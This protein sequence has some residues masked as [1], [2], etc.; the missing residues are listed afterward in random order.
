LSLLRFHIDPLL[1][2]IETHRSVIDAA[3]SRPARW[4]G[5][6]RSPVDGKEGSMRRRRVAKAFNR[7][8]RT[9]ARSELG[10]ITIDDLLRLNS[11]VGG[12]GTLRTTG[13]RIGE[14]AIHHRRDALPGLAEQALN[15]ANDG[16]EPP[17]LAAARLHMELLLIHGFRDCNGRTIRLASAWI[18]L[19]AGY[20]STLL[21]AVEQHAALVPGSYFRSFRLLRTSEPTQYSEWL[22]TA[23][24]HQVEATKWAHLYRDRE[25][26]MRSVLHDAGVPRRLH[27]QA[28]SSHER[29]TASDAARLLRDS[30]RW[31]AD[32]ATMSDTDQH[33]ARLQIQRLLREET[34]DS[35]SRLLYR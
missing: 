31:A 6:I 13:A 34:R 24:S 5:P 8:A 18:L 2:Q 17:A 16:F 3:L 7:L 15:R 23:L 20:R 14:F 10:D 35:A 28:L 29:G 22:R 33:R 1:D 27:E 12:E 4:D 21:T 11:E 9:Q 32:S 30:P 26:A 25:T 19:R